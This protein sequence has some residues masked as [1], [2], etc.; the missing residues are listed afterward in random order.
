MRRLLLAMACAAGVWAG[1]AAQTL[2]GGAEFSAK[3]PANFSVGAGVEYR[4]TNQWFK[5]TDQWSVDASVG[6]KPL[7]YL[8]VAAAYKFLD[9][10]N[11]GGET[12]KGKVYN[13]YW[14]AKHRVS[15]SATGEV[16]VWKFELSLRERYQYTYRPGHL[17]P[18]EDIEDGNRTID[19]KSTHI[20]RSRLEVEFKPNKKSPW[21]P[22]VSFE[23]YS[24]L[25]HINHDDADK[26]YGAKFYDKWR[27][28]AGT[29]IKINKHNSLQFFYRYTRSVEPDENDSPQT[30]GLVYSFSL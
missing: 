24:M 14:D 1:G 6:Y 10:C 23:L 7:K 13:D 30:V 15:L 25:K 22:F 28:M 18:Y 26:T 9:V 19:A 29:D 8:K 27:I 5:T 17:I 11:A 21:K 2:L 3:L 12:K 4:T 20:L 16:K